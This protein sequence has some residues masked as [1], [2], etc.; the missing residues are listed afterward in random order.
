MSAIDQRLDIKIGEMFEAIRLFQGAGAVAGTSHDR[1]P[2]PTNLESPDPDPLLRNGNASQTPDE[3][4]VQLASMHFE[5][6][7]TSWLQALVLSAPQSVLDWRR[8][9]VLLI[10]RFGEVLD[11]PMADLKNLQETDS[12]LE[13]HEKFELIRTRLRLPEEYLVSAYHAGLHTETQMHVQMFQP[14]S[15]RHCFML[16]KLYE[17]AHPRRPANPGNLG[18]SSFNGGKHSR[19]PRK[20]WHFDSKQMQSTE[21]KPI[22]PQ[23]SSAATGRMFLT[24]EKMNERRSKGLCF[25]CDEKYSLGIKKLNSLC[26]DEEI[27]LEKVEISVNA[28]AG[29]TGYNTMRVRVIHAKQSL[30]ILIDSGSTH[31]FIDKAVAERFGCELT[32]LSLTKVVVTDGSCLD[33]KS[34]LKDFS[35]TFHDTS[36]NTDAMVLPLRCCDMV[37][38]IQWIETLG[39]VVWDFKKLA[40]EF[41]V[42]ARKIVLHGIKPA[43]MRDAKAKSI[44]KAMEMGLQLTMICVTQIHDSTCFSTNA[45]QQ[46][47][48]IESLLTE[49]SDLFEEP[50]EL[51]PWRKDHNHKI[52]FASETNPINQRPYR[53]AIHQKDKNDKMV[54]DMLQSGVFRNNS[55]AFASPIVLVKK[56]DGSWHMCID[57]RWLNEA[58][59]K[60]RFPIPLIED[61]MDELGDPASFPRLT[62][63]QDITK[64]VCILMTFTRHR[65]KRIMAITSMS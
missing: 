35:L 60:D 16:G 54:K 17:A 61:L 45:H 58:T 1:P 20:Y 39:P 19:F 40:M 23:N 9:C 56:K 41:R 55:G 8:Y 53:Y 43:S 33:V 37:L 31:N 62:Y 7:T 32:L 6:V 52:A 65:L 27:E 59:I 64:C 57:Y 30:F 14:S 21:T 5:D 13:Y 50:T 28:M 2:L 29:I 18:R 12:I 42:G 48:A 24:Q 4:K 3:L 10:E 25:F 47:P 22:L 51:P 38:G 46:H 34:Q 36:F 49:Y 44:N 15:V 63:V 26:S 11:D